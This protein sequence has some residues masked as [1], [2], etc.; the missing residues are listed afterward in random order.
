MGVHLASINQFYD[1]FNTKIPQ[2]HRDF[3]H[4]YFALADKSLFTQKRFLTKI[5]LENKIR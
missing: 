3:L 2:E 4:D 1:R 5:E